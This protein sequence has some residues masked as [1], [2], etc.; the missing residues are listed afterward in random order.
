MDATLK[1]FIIPNELCRRAGIVGTWVRVN[2]LGVF[3][4]QHIK[5]TNS[6]SVSLYGPS[7]ASVFNVRQQV[8]LFEPILRKLVNEANGI[9]LSVQE[10]MG[11][12]VPDYKSELLKLSRQYRSIIRACLENLQEETV[13][14]KATYKEELQNY[15]TIF[16]SVECIWHLCEILFVENIPGG[17]VLPHLLEWVRFHF[18]KYERNAASLLR[19]DVI[20]AELQPCYW[21]TVI[22]SL[23]QGRIELVQALLEVHSSADGKP[24][25]LAI[26]TLRTMPL[27]NIY[28]GISVSEFNLKWKHWVLDTQSK[29]EAKMFSSERHLNLVMRLAVGDEVAWGEM[30]THREPWYAFL[31]AS[32]FFKEPTVKAFELGQFARQCIA[33]VGGA[34][35]M[36]HLDQV[37]LASMELDI[38][39]VIKEI[40]QMSENGWFVSHLVDL[41]YHAGRLEG[42]YSDETKVIGSR[43]RESFLLDYGTLLMGHHSLWQVGLNYLDHCPT[44][45]LSTIEL[46]LPAL[47]LKSEARTQK[48]IREAHKR[49]MPQIVQSICKVHTMDSI[50]K[51]R[52]GNAL[53]WGLKSQDGG[54]TSLI[55]DKF[56]RKYK[57]T[58]VLLNEDL[59]DNLGSSMLISDRL[60]FLGKYF[61]FHKE[62]RLKNYKEA[63]NI[64]ISLLA[65]KLTPRYFWDTLLCDAIN[66]LENNVMVISSTDTY[67]LLHSL[68]EK[69]ELPELKD[70]IDLIRL[71][72][73][74]NLSRALLYEMQL[75][76]KYT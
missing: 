24:F 72:A 27:Y 68:E 21:E 20:G 5:T 45:G 11:S 29:I 56:L 8:V 18:P 19:E 10:L 69:C 25:Q 9:F 36:R 41:L 15:I 26:Q 38:I 54:F 66:L 71:G 60:I 6:D 74:R 73:A 42:L 14:A 63:A 47:P 1:T 3:P 62:Y 28:G 23:M 34:V 64:L 7:D 44:E 70:K 57:E 55:A 35:K 12:N 61:E 51:G 67:T 58:G 39:Q 49:D 16:Y 65:S 59:L 43:L 40:Q 48:I 32:L 4:S 2:E 33:K 22:G 17:I 37:L 30:Q 52:L 75:D 46:L 53:T 31:A 50:S 13:R 76:K